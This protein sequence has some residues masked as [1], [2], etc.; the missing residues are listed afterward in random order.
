MHLHLSGIEFF[1]IISYVLIGG[2]FIRL[3]E[4]W[5]KDTSVGKA[6]AFMW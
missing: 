4:A 2:F 5:L 6:L 1:K 3:M